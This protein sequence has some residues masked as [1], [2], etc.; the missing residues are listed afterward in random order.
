MGVGELL[1]LTVRTAAQVAFCARM[2]EARLTAAERRL[3]EHL[4]LDAAAADVERDVILAERPCANRS[5][6]C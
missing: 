5:G 3:A 1:E 2:V 4:E 6:T